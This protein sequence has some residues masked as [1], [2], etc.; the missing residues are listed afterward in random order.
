MQE[1]DAVFAAVALALCVATAGFAQ[2]PPSN[3][4]IGVFAD[5]AR[6]SCCID[7]APFHG[8]TL[9]IFAVL[10]GETA[11]GITQAEFRLIFTDL[12][13][14]IPTWIA[15]PGASRAIGSP[16]PGPQEENYG[17]D[18]AFSACQGS[19]AGDAVHLGSLQVVNI[20]GGPGDI[21]VTRRLPPTNPSYD[22]PNLVL[23]DAPVYTQV[24]LT[25]QT[26]TLDPGQEPVIF[27]TGLNKGSACDA[28]NCGVVPVT[29]KTWSS[30]KELYR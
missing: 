20:S 27:K 29:Q 24:C 5:S 26:P 25:V 7:I 3:G 17:V 16:L 2:T 6:T 1:N 10:A 15:D 19:M 8:K 18:V 13:G 22:C 21:L 14:Y 11:G 23:C 9:E 30:M 4:Y 12:T 28:T